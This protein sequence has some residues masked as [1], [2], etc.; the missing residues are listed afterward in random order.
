MP[1]ARSPG[2][3]AESQ[4]TAPGR[5]RLAGRRILVVG[6]GQNDY[7]EADPP[8]GNGRAMAILFAREGARVAVADRDRASAEATAARIASEGST[9]QVVIADMAR[10]ADPQ[11]MVDQARTALGGLDG[12]VYNVGIAG[13]HGLDNATPESWDLVLAVN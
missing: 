13:R 3:P 4:G 12:V 6:A 8:I 2:L 1:D 11:A 7:G 5:G 9:A 10:P